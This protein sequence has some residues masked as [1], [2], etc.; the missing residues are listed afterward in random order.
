AKGLEVPETHRACDGRA[1]EPRVLPLRISGVWKERGLH[2]TAHNRTLSHS[3]T[4]F[5]LYL[6]YAHIHIYTHTH[7]HTHTHLTISLGALPLT[8][9]Y[10]H[11]TEQGHREIKTHLLKDLHCP[12]LLSFP[13]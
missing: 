3:L 2:M 13:L 1:L 6:T 12:S 10:T 7:T 5:G 11:V 8:H 9:T 4:A